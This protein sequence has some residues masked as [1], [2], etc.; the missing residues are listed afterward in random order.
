MKSIVFLFKLPHGYRTIL[1]NI[2]LITT[3]IVNLYWKHYIT[4]CCCVVVM[5][6]CGVVVITTAQLHSTKP[7]LR[8]CAGSK[9]AHAMSEIRDG[10]DL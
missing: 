5:W 9:P 6:H 4:G 8:F 3:V 10:E 1:S 7:K 2:F